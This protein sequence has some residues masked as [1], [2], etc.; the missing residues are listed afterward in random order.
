MLSVRPKVRGRD[1]ARVR[2][3]YTGQCRGEGT[4]VRASLRPKNSIPIDLKD[5]AKERI[6]MF[7]IIKGVDD[8]G[9]R[10]LVSQ[11]FCSVWAGFFNLMHWTGF[12]QLG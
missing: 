6:K 2:A 8:L 7:Q 3:Y 5:T 4:T 10:C 12:S 1:R 9:R 11:R